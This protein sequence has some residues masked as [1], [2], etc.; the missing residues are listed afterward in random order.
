MSLLRIGFS[1]S[2]RWF[3]FFRFGF[4]T[5]TLVFLRTGLVFFRIGLVSLSFGSVISFGLDISKVDVSGLPAKSG[6]TR[7]Y[8]RTTNVKIHIKHVFIY[9][10]THYCRLEAK[11]NWPFSR[12]QGFTLSSIINSSLF[13][14]RPPGNFTTDYSQDVCQV[15]GRRLF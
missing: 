8:R 5:R 11:D 3:G 12:S 14:L 10:S 6:I 1:F 15:S 2:G 7:F 9:K 13:P 4:S